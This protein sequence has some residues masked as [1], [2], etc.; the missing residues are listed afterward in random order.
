MFFIFVIG[1]AGCGKSVLTA[2]LEKWLAT[3]ELA[4]TVVNLDPGVEDPPYTSDVD[5]REY[6]NYGQVMHEFGLGP[7]GALVASLDMAVSHV[8]DLREEIID[9]GRDYVII[10]CPGQMELF[11]YR[12]SGP[13]LVSSL[14]NYDPAASLYLLDANIARTPTGYLSSMLLGISINIRFLLPQISILS[15][16]DI[17][18]EEK[19]QEVIS[20]STNPFL[21]QDALD[22]TA[23]GM[24]KEYSSSILRILEDIGSGTSLFPISAKQMVG[25]ET[26]Y[27]EIQ[28]VLAG[29]E[30]YLTYE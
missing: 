3:S 22:M 25:M 23:E 1:T 12:N 28:R 27:A 8:D 19:V 15:K 21:L 9:I 16:A 24:I 18:S 20:W 6:V 29:G 30:D 7:N 13:L 14:R 17:I 5:I 10:D 11:A 2:A 26:L 4:V